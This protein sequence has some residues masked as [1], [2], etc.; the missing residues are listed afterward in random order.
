[1]TGAWL[2]HRCA[3]EALASYNYDDGKF[4]ES[5]EVVVETEDLTPIG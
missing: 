3:I 2:E 5:G 4:N 1:M